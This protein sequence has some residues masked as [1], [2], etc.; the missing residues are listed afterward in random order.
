MAIINKFKTFESLGKASSFEEAKAILESE[1]VELNEGIISSIKNYFSRLLGGA[2][3]KIDDILRRY[4]E[5]EDGYWSKW[6]DAQTKFNAADLLS[7]ESKANPVERQ[8]NE[9]AK[10][11]I[12]KLQQQVDDTRKGVNDALFKQAEVLTRD[13]DRLKD[14]LEFNKAK[15]DE[16]VAKDS[17]EEAKKLSD[18]SVI[19]T[20][21][22]RIGQ[23]V[24]HA[25]KK[26]E[27]FRSK[28]A[29][30][31]AT[32]TF[33]DF[34]KNKGDV[35]TFQEL[36]VDDVDDF[37]H[38]QF[39]PEHQAKLRSMPKQNLKSLRDYISGE[40]KKSKAGSIDT[41]KSLKSD[42][43]D[44]D[45][46]DPDFKNKEDDLHKQIDLA[47]KA[48]DNTSTNLQNKVNYIDKLLLLG[49]I[50][51]AQEIKDN[52]QMVTPKTKEEL[53][54][55]KT[56]QAIDHAIE[57]TSKDVAK[58]TTAHVEEVIDA[59]VHKYFKD[60]K[61]IVENALGVPIDP[62]HYEHLKNDLIALFGKLVFYYKGINREFNART[63]QIGL[64]DFAAKIFQFKKDNDALSR[65]LTDAELQKEF[66]EY[67]K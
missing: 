3:K 27:E 23:S 29:D 30:A 22:N 38:Q 28:Y 26:D 55:K 4:K 15:T 14:Y 61:D 52:P 21:Y 63:L 13:N 43:D 9:E 51:I 41:I 50:G 47:K 16:Q 24:E 1:G 60:G 67:E 64:L 11:R 6:A 59:Q 20:L 57:K 54:D 48:M 10:N 34:E 5:N 19:N 2:V 12:R 46:K 44:L 39:D 25:R 37:V 33:S 45:Q 42:L 58:P 18:E 17:Y 66:D 53:G 32:S 31:T 8:K 35:A 56:D 65:D 36:G 40:I 62:K 49:Q 7:K